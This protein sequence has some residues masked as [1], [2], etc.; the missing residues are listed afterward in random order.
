[1]EIEEHLTRAMAELERAKQEG[2]FLRAGE[3]AFD[4][5][6]N[7]RKKLKEANEIEEQ[8]RNQSHPKVED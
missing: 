4:I 7:F 8:C 5:I 1:M 6:P 3:L 2:D